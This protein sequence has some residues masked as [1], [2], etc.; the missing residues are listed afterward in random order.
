MTYTTMANDE[1]PELKGQFLVAYILGIVV[2][3]VCNCDL[4][5]QQSVDTLQQYPYVTYTIVTPATDTTSDWLGDNRQ[6]NCYFQIDVHSDKT[7]TANDLANKLFAALHDDGY[8]RFFKQARIIP[9]SFAN[10]ANR[11]A[12]QGI[13]YDN[14]FGFDCIFN[15]TGSRVYQESEL[16]FD[17]ISTTIDT[18]DSGKNTSVSPTGTVTSNNKED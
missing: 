1:M 5:L 13:N 16:N 12:L 8:R 10:F 15:I 18:I 2:N 4:L 6:Y 7:F 11:T 3:Q 9:Q 14:D 17:Y